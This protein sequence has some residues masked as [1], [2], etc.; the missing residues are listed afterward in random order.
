MTHNAPMEPENE[1][2][3]AYIAQGPVSQA[4]WRFAETFWVE[5]DVRATWKAAHPTLRR[6]WAQTWLMPLRDEVR[7][8]G[9][10]L[11]EVVEVFTD[12]EVEHDLWEPFARGLAV[13][14]NS[15]PVSR[16]TWGTKVNPDYVA[17]DVMLV[18]LLPIPSDGVIRP[19]E[20]YMSVPL[21]MQFE[22]DPGW[23]VLNF[24]SEEIPVPGWPPQM[25]AGG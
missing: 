5:H 16:E 25:G 8:E 3:A 20:S 17:P 2:L 18:R 23:R 13:T 24:V 19:G 15:L 1:D 14:A 21:L 9:Y 12:D 7:A 22:E 10:D 4:A 6:C 11:D